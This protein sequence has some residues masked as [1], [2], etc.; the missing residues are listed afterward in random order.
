MSLEG[1]RVVLIGRIDERSQVEKLA[2]ECG[3]S[4]IKHLSKAVEYVVVP[5]DPVKLA[6]AEKTSFY[7]KAVS[8]KLSVITSSAFIKKYS[9]REGT[10]PPE[11]EPEPK[12][13]H[14][15][16]RV[17]RPKKKTSMSEKKK[18]KGTKKKASTVKRKRSADDSNPRPHKAPRAST[19]RNTSTPRK[20]VKRTP[21]H[22]IRSALLGG[23]A[24]FP[25]WQ[26]R[27][28]NGVVDETLKP[29]FEGFAL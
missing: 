12:A 17:G 26:L 6:K 23:D 16:P 29:L 22:R 24:A 20:Q 7:Q 11:P 4:L 2:V 21:P 14:T 25:R 27:S 28:Y 10:P 8:V 5:S 18:L 13:S 15:S 9:T 3:A 19:P 1:K